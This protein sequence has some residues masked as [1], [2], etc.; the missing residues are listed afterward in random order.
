MSGLSKSGLR[1]RI[2][3]A[4]NLRLRMLASEAQDGGSRNIGMIDVSS[5]QTAKI[6]RIFSSSSAPA[7]MNEKFDAINIFEKVVER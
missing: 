2:C 3:C 1:V 4:K 6:V 5:N 7:F